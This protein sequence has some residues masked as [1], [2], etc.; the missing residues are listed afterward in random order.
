VKPI[1]K[2]PPP[3]R[4]MAPEMII[5][6]SLQN[7]NWMISIRIMVLDPGWVILT[8]RTCFAREKVKSSGGKTPSSNET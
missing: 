5:L 8:G 7:K 6:H 4:E 1:K 2:G 3:K